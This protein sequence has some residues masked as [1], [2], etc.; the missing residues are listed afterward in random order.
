METKKYESLASFY[1]FYLSQHSNKICRYFHY[2]GTTMVIVGFLLILI[3][4]AWSMLW[5]LLIAGYGPAWIG[6]FFFEK[7]KPATFK[8]PIYSLISDFIMYYE[9]ITFKKRDFSIFSNVSK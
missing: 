5:T 2:L 9:W 4:G 1:P 8:Y 6:H 3:N 7:N